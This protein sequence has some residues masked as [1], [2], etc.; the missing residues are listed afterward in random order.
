MQCACISCA[1]VNIFSIGPQRSSIDLEIGQYL[2]ACCAVH[3]LRPVKEAIVRSENLRGAIVSLT[4]IINGQFL[5][6][7]IFSADKLHAA[8]NFLL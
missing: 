7:I 4:Y 1:L 6:Q 8:V 3:F 2:H 5:K